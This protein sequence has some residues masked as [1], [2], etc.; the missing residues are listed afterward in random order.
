MKLLS[1][2]PSLRSIAALAISIGFGF[3]AVLC[4]TSARP[5]SSL[6]KGLPSGWNDATSQ[7][8]T[9]VRTRFP[10]GS[11]AQKLTDGL[12]AEGFKPTWFET[13]GEYGAKRD[14]GSFVCNIAARVFWRV[15][16]NGAVSAIRGTY[17]EEGCL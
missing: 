17:N 11:S 2:K 14:E 5:P 16:Q 13:G 1:P 8:D 4:W 12:G 6:T 3:V 7:F 15:G 10:I 9:R